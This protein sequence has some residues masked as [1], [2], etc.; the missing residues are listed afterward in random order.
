M[1]GPIGIEQHVVQPVVAVHQR[2]AARL[3]QQPRCHQSHCGAEGFAGLPALIS[4]AEFVQ[5]RYR[6]PS[7]R[8]HPCPWRVASSGFGIATTW[9]VRPR[10]VTPRSGRAARPGPRTASRASC[11][12]AA[13]DLV[14]LHGGCHVGEQQH[15]IGSVVGDL[16]VIAP[17]DRDPHPVRDPRVESVL[18]AVA[19][20]DPVPDGLVLRGQL[21]RECVWQR[22]VARRHTSPTP[23]RWRRSGRCRSA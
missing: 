4:G 2:E 12:R 9:E 23:G 14:A 7:A 3:G 13:T 6:P 10:R 11:G 22:Q 16:A 18:G 15:E 17:G 20:G 8:P 21:D 19:E 1:R 5:C